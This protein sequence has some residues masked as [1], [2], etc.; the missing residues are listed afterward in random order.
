MKSNNSENPLNKP[1]PE[2]RQAAESAF[3]QS[4]EE[5]KDLLIQKQK[6]EARPPANQENDTSLE[7]I[8]EDDWE[9]LHDD[10]TNFFQADDSE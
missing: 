4:L 2:S 10:L 7:A 3:K 9:D 5:L 1:S 6:R 8:S